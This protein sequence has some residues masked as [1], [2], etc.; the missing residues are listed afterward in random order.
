MLAAA[1]R[2]RKAHEITRVYKRGL[3]GGADGVLSVKAA[4]S[5]RSQSRAV[6]IV[7]KKV[8]KRAVVRNRIRRR[9][10]GVLAD[11]WGTVKPGYDIVLTIHSNLSD[12]PTPK[13]QQLCLA[14]LQRAKVTP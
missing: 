4:P 8:D 9:V 2:L 6:V 7:G 10:A 13:L 11:Q 14:A 3:Y 1:N 12:L 5:G